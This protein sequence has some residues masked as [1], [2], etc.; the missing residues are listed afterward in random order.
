MVPFRDPSVKYQG[1]NAVV[2]KSYTNA[3]ISSKEG[4][5]IV[6]MDPGPLFVR[7]IFI[8]LLVAA[9]GLAFRSERTTIKVFTGQN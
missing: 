6:I 8:V 9:F 3:N 5:R 4:G 1:P 7:I 2:E